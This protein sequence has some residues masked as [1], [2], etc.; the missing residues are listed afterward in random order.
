VLVLSRKR[1]ESIVIDNIEV[2]VLAIKGNRVQLGIS[3][4]GDVEIRR[5]ELTARKEGEA[6]S[7]LG[8]KNV[9]SAEIQTQ[10][11]TTRTAA[12]RHSIGELI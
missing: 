10:S 1:N 3:A 11:A 4:P 2:R 7:C 6:K 5:A 8:E 9:Q 12:I